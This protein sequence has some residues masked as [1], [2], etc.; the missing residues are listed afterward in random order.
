MLSFR[1]HRN[2]QQAIATRVGD[3]IRS[4]FRRLSPAECTEKNARSWLKQ[5]V[6]MDITYWSVFPKEKH[7]WISGSCQSPRLC[8]GSGSNNTIAITIR[9]I[10]EGVTTKRR[11]ES[12]PNPG[13]NR[14]AITLSTISRSRT[15]LTKPPCRVCG[16]TGFGYPILA[17]FT[18]TG[19]KL[20]LH[21]DGR[22]RSTRKTPC[23]SPKKTTSLPY[24]PR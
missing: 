6:G 5:L 9:C 23:L 2:G 18:Q 20:L 3:A 17:S 16:R 24:H 13:K 19:P 1:L 8:V 15:S 14:L 7:L 21:P 4:S 10:G 12:S 22:D 11:L